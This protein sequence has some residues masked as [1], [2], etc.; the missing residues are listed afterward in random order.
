MGGYMVVLMDASFFWHFDFLLKPPQPVR[1]LFLFGFHEV[2]EKN[3][4]VRMDEY[5]MCKHSKQEFEC[6]LRMSEQSEPL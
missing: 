6:H 4:S 2:N 3:L 1:G 5:L